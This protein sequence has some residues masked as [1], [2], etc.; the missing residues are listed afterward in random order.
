MQMMA[1]P[2]TRAG[3]GHALLLTAGELRDRLFE[4]LVGK[5]DLARDLAHLAVDLVLL[6][7]LDPEAEG[8]VVVYGHRR[9]ERVALEHDA[10]VAVLDGDARDVAA[11]D[12]DGALRRLDEARDG[13][14][15][16]SCRSRRGRGR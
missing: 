16:W 5:V 7:L 9:E 13:A 11:L 4:L 14:A 15:R 2:V 10:D 1:G 8:D 6:C 12:H 3:D